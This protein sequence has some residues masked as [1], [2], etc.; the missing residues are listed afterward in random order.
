[1]SPEGQ[2]GRLDTGGNAVPSIE[3]VEEVVIADDQPEHRQ[4]FLDARDVGYGPLAEE[5]GT[6][7]L[8][9]K[10]NDLFAKL[11]LEGGDVKT[12]LDG[13]ATEANKMIAENAG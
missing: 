6:P 1:V 9:T 2:Q 3:G 12:A 11:W 10:V 8:S 5:A 7:G 13:I 4:Y